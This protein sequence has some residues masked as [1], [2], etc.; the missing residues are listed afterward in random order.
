MWPD[1]MKPA[2]RFRGRIAVGPRGA[3]VAY[4]TG[5]PRLGA[6]IQWSQGLQVFEVEAP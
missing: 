6:P 5:A 3:R 1:S 2:A 4:V